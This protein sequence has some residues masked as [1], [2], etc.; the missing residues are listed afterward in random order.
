MNTEKWLS[1]APLI[2]VLSA[3]LC[4]AAGCAAP[5]KRVVNVESQPSGARVFFGAGA[6]ESAAQPKQYLGTTPFSWTPEQKGNGEFVLPGAL[7]YSTFV[8]PAA[9]IEA[10]WTN[11]ATQRI[12]FHGGTIA[13]PADKI[14]PG[15]FFDAPK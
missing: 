15:L 2:S 9:V 11:G 8:P 10:R 7:V 13:T 14:P 3:L 4:L 6:N 1:S 12:I 5:P